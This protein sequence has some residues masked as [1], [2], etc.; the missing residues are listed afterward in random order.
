MTYRELLNN[1]STDGLASI[2]IDG[3]LQVIACIEH[4]ASTGGETCFSRV[5]CKKCISKLLDKEI[6]PNYLKKY[7]KYL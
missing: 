3:D 1:I 5:H 7:K 6:D 2:I 4:N